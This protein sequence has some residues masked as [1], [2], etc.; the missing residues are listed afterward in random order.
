[1]RVWGSARWVH[2]GVGVS[3]RGVGGWVH[4]GVG[5][6]TRGVGGWVHEGV[7]ISR[8]HTWEGWTHDFA[9]QLLCFLP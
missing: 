2:E 8:A 7:G 3:T 5:I 4:E 1:M 9:Q 6:R